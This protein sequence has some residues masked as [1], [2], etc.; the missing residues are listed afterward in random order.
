MIYKIIPTGQTGE[1]FS[2]RRGSVTLRILTLD[3]YVLRDYRSTEVR[4]IT[5]KAQRGK[6]C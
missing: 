5:D 4:L 3:G 6:K 2:A 1:L